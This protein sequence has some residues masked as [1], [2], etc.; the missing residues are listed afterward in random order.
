MMLKNLKISQ[1]YEQKAPD[2]SSHMFMP[3]SQAFM[4]VVIGPL[5]CLLIVS[6]LKNN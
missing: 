3:S 4:A 2:S 1:K 6:I 5:D